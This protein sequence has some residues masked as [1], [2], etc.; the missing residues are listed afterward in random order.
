[1]FFLLNI[2]YF[3]GGKTLEATAEITW[4]PFHILWIIHYP[5]IVHTYLRIIHESSKDIHGFFMNNPNNPY[6][7]QL[8][9]NNV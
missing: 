7:S 3:S 2:T 8:F 5:F 4:Q 9:I 6:I 1:M